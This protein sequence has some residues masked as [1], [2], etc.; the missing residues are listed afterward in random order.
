MA[1]MTERRKA[2]AGLSPREAAF[3]TG[4]TE[5][6]INQAIDR[7][8][9]HAL[10]ARRVED[11][12]RTLGFP[13]LV[14]LQL[15]S[16]IG[17]LLSAEGKRLL[18]E[19]LMTASGDPANTVNIGPMEVR[20]AMQVQRVEERVAQIERARAFVVSDPE[21]RAGEPTVRGTRIPVYVLAELAAQG[22]GTEELLEDYPSLT[23]E[24]LEA[25]LLFARMYPRRGRPPRGP[26]KDGVVVRKAP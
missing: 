21:V 9:V 13:D 3:V 19:Q 18:R 2:P 1:T 6:T 7:E 15:R 14:Y 12:E 24:S 17:A 22:A 10:P 5:K 25:A 11:H 26:W 23:A 16:E 20:I 4:L 8:E